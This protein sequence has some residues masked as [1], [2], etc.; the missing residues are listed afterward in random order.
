MKELTVSQQEAIDGGW[1]WYTLAGGLDAAGDAAERLAPCCGDATPFMEA[2]G[3]GCEAAGE[4]VGASVGFR[5]GSNLMQVI[6]A[7]L[8]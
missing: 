5:A 7:S 6:S 4:F 8:G 2:V 3:A 1:S